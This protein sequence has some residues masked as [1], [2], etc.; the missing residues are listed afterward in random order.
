MESASS[1]M[2]KGFTDS[3]YSPELL[4]RA[5]VLREN[6]DAVALVD[7]RPLLR[8]E[9]HAVE[10]GVHEQHVVVLVGG[11]RLLEVVAELQLDRHPV[12]R[13]VAMVDDRDECL[14]A[15]EV[16]R[17]L[18]HVRAR[19]HELRDE[20][21]PLANLRVLFEEEVER[22]EAAQDVLGE[23]GTIDAQDQEVAP[24]A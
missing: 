10:H 23:V 14:D 2:S 11:H 9:V 15:L 6:R 21:H 24:P 13:P 8:D 5:R 3:A 4:V 20:R 17:V 19:G 18:R 16:L 7:D 22:G 1:W 12:G